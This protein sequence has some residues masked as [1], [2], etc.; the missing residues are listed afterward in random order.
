M[1][2]EVSGPIM[3]SSPYTDIALIADFLNFY[4]T[5]GPFMTTRNLFS[6]NPIGR[7]LTLVVILL[8]WG[9]GGSRPQN[10]QAAVTGW[11]ALIGPSGT[12]TSGTVSALELDN[13]NNL[14][15]GGTFATAGGVTV[16]S[17]ALWNGID[18]DHSFQS[19]WHIG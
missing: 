17:I 12:G 14:Y 4:I 6:R 13:S 15:V 2:F 19:F 18:K 8:L 3:I 11:N 5:Q 1:L 9:M 16:N 7:F 10:A